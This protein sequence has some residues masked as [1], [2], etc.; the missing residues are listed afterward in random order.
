MHYIVAVYNEDFED[1][2]GYIGHD[3]QPHK[4]ELAMETSD[5]VVFNN[6]EEAETEGYRYTDYFRVL[7]LDG[8]G[9]RW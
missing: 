1:F 9:V 7:K 8:K 2:E 6:M 3:S 4:D 5:A